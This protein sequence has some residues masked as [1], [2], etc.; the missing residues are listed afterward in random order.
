MWYVNNYLVP[1]MLAQGIPESDINVWE[2]VTGLGN[3]ESCIRCF[4]TVGELDGGTW[5]LQDDVI[6]CSDFKE[7]TERYDD[8]IVAGFA[9]S[10]DSDVYKGIKEDVP[11]GIV[12]VNQLWYSF[13]CI[14]IPNSIAKE[15][16]D[17]WHTVGMHDGEL[18]RTCVNDKKNDDYMFRTFLF[19][20]HKEL[21]VRNLAPNLVDHIDYMLGGSIINKGRKGRIVSSLFWEEQDLLEDLS[22]KLA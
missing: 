9:S 13:C 7:R 5:H 18:I 11:C 10:Y 6:I 2:D 15:C 16:A 4:E 19:N 8:G 1:S 14:R 20:Y 12:P 22:K 3:L 17:W 21:S